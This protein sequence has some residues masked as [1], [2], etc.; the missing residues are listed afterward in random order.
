[1]SVTTE[2]SLWLALICL[3]LAAAGSWFLYRNNKLDLSGKRGKYVLW[4]LHA[5]RFLSLFI[6]SFLLLGPLLKVILRNT[7]KPVL[8][9]AV[10]QSASIV[11]TKDSAFYRTAFM[12]EMQD[13][14]QDL[15]DDYEVVWWNFGKEITN[16]NTTAF[17]QKQTNIAN[18]LSEARNTYNGQNLGAV[19]LVSDG[20]YNDG[21]NPLYETRNISS[22]VYTIALGDTNQRKDLL[23][24]NVR[25][26][27]VVYSGNIF[28]L[29]IDVAAF[30]C[31][32]S[33]TQLSVSH[34]GKTL[35]TQNIGINSNQYFKTLQ[36]DLE[37]KESGT[38]H[39]T[40]NLSRLT[41][42]ATYVN[43]TFDVFVN[44]VNGK[45]KVL[46]LANTPHPDLGA[47]EKAI[48]ANENYEVK[49]HL[50]TQDQAQPDI[51]QYNL[52]VLHQ[53]PGWKGE[54]LSII[55]QIKEKQVPML[56]V[57]GTQTGLNYLSQ[58]DQTVS[59][60][61]ARASVNDAQAVFN[62]NFSLFTLTDEEVAHIQKFPPLLSPF[63][64]Y[65]INTEA[66]ILLKQQIGYVKTDYPLIVFGKGAGSKAAWICGEGFWKW[67]LADYELSKQQTTQTLAGKMVQFLAA[68]KDQSLFRITSKKRFDENERIVMDAEVY[69]ESYELINTPE[70]SITIE[71]AGK[72][73]FNYTFS[74]KGKAYTLDAGILA[75]GTYT[76]VA[77]AT[78]GS[79]LVQQKGSF[80]VVP[81]QVEYIQ[82][83]ADHQLLNELSSRTNGAMFYPNQLAELKN[84]LQQN[85]TIKPVIYKKEEL[86]SWINLK[87]LFVFIVAMMSVEWF[88]RKWNGSI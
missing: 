63:G 49:T 12:K 22:P 75:P 54:G 44:V 87:W 71:S 2:Y 13:L 33:N 35:I 80:T 37:A 46:I 32:N 82:T 47:Y 27:Q 7:E 15:S 29:Q 58:L 53:L 83:V 86:K 38:Q 10:D 88:V 76:Y 26:N 55:R 34:K 48:G 51:A 64:N 77:K 42:E 73:S 56:I 30:G 18:V 78:I 45:Q 9:F 23:V 6:I 67:R 40:V 50:V 5:F 24:K 68:K 74:K 19:V 1:M 69:N 21:S 16:E 70:V 52:V 3:L 85:E 60:S 11:S 84:A 14:K 31:A 28:P 65:R 72:R 66:D 79:K 4:M 81:L 61:A 62:P 17:D 57:L 36:V 41:N 39:Y 59:V 25:H 20:I 43:N 8:L